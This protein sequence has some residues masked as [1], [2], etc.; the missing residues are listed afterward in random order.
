MRK[1]EPCMATGEEARRIKIERCQ[2]PKYPMGEGPKNMKRVVKAEEKR[3]SKSM[4]G[5][6]QT[7]V[8]IRRLRGGGKI[9]NSIVRVREQ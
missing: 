4:V 7:S 8:G 5:E 6:M 2:K 3:E 9:C 1:L